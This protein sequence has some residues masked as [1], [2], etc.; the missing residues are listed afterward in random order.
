MVPLC[1]GAPLEQMA[2]LLGEQALPIVVDATDAVQAA[3]A[4]A[5]ARTVTILRARSD[6]LAARKSRAAF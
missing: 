1:G 2:S 4:A 3:L 6:N 5:L